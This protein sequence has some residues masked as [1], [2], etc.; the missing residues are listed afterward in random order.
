MS[1]EWF[2]ERQ[3][4]RLGALLVDVENLYYA[5]KDIHADDPIET[6]EAVLEKLRA[7]LEE[8]LRILPVVQNAYAPFDFHSTQQLINSLAL[9]GFKLEHVLATPKKNSADLLLAIDCMELLYQRD[10]IAHFVLVGGDRDYIPVAQRVMK[11]AKKVIIVCPRHA[12][13]GDLLT[14]V[15]D[16]NY[17]DT[18]ELLEISDDEEET[19]EAA[20]VSQPPD[21]KPSATMEP[22][23]ESTPPPP[24]EQAPTPEPEPVAEPVQTVIKKRPKEPVVAQIPPPASMDELV[25]ILADDRELERQK[26]LMSLI[27][28]FQQR[29]DVREVYLSPFFR[30]MNEAFPDMA[31]FQRKGLLN[32]LRSHGAIDIQTRERDQGDGTYAVIVIKDW[33][34]PLVRECIPE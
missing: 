27:L 31:N 13:S 8:E 4:L 16:E 10:D 5:I 18:E 28:E 7:L 21:A 24:A 25:L 3:P 11:N 19:V 6:T 34:H 30:E 32:R 20:P 26:K 17:I 22:A 9:M 14:I 33:E 12:M 1:R 29:L 23:P 15:G 2:K